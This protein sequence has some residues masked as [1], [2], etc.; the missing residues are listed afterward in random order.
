MDKNDIYT[1]SSK[2]TVRLSILRK[3]RFWPYTGF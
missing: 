2:T 1:R 3:I